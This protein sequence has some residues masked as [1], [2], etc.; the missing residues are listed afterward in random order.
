MGFVFD[1]VP[2][3]RDLLCE[4]ISIIEKRHNEQ[5][6]VDTPNK[7][8]DNV[9]EDLKTF[10]EEDFKNIKERKEVVEQKIRDFA[11]EHGFLVDSL[12]LSSR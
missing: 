10:Y 5:F 8:H 3:L 12:N 11:R 9:S 1:S 7:W 6:G 2:S 4:T